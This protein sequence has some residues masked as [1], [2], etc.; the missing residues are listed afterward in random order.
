M[1]RA[2]SGE[3]VHL[4]H[5][6]LVHVVAA[7]YGQTPAEVREWPADDFTDALLFMGVTRG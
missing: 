7:R 5:R 1:L 2:M 6:V 4:P 3:S